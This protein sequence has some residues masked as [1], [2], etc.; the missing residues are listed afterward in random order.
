MGRLHGDWGGMRCGR[1][2]RDG[3]CDVRSS[4]KYISF[5]DIS[6][7]G[8]ADMRGDGPDSGAAAQTDMCRAGQIA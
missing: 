8:E 1:G 7:G 3:H 5:T 2:G 6:R 4:K